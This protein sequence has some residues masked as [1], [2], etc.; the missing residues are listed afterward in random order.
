MNAT[1]LG[2]KE[3]VLRVPKEYFHLE[4]D[5]YFSVVF[6]TCIGYCGARTST[7]PNSPFLPCKLLHLCIAVGMFIM[8]KLTMP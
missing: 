4:D 6:H 3:S 7:S 8:I 2:M 5:Y 1:K